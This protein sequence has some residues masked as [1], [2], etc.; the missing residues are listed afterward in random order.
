MPN[1]TQVAIPDWNSISEKGV[2]KDM[3]FTVLTDVFL[4]EDYGGAGQLTVQAPLND[5]VAAVRYAD[6]PE[7]ESLTEYDCNLLYN[8]M[9]LEQTVYGLVGDRLYPYW[10]NAD[11]PEYMKFYDFTE[12]CKLHYETDSAVQVRMV[13]GRWVLAEDCYAFDRYEVFEGKVYRYSYG[14][15]HHR[16]RTKKAKRMLVREVPFCKLYK[17]FGE[18]AEKY[19][20]YDKK[21]GTDAYGY[22]FNPNTHWERFQVGG[23]WL[24][25]YLVK[26]DCHTVVAGDPSILLKH[27]MEM[28]APEGYY[29][30]TGARKKDIAWDVMKSMAIQSEQEI[31]LKYEKWYQNGAIPR[32]RKDLYFTERGI[33]SKEMLIYAKGETLEEHLRRMALSEEYR[34]TLR[35]Y[36][37]LDKDGWNDRMKVGCNGKARSN[38]DDQK[39]Y[40]AVEKYIDSL[41]DDAVLV[42]LDCNI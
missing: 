8:Q 22:Y 25:R 16:K 31:F 17:D 28:N 30:V 3:H 19:C 15:L 14:R 10:M 1:R 34:Y 36:A 39:W 41:P 42:S 33:E 26:S 5:L 37:F 20:G 7:R 4:P 38:E 35:T 18:Y 32:N 13:D 12:Q 29:W 27:R 6:S 11:D 24:N 2:Y 23:R 9:C 21:E 40:Q